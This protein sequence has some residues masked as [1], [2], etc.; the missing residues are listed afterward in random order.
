M[1]R[2]NRKY[3]PAPD[4]YEAFVIG[5]SKNVSWVRAPSGVATRWICAVFPKRVLMSSSRRVG[6]QSARLADRDSVYR[7]TSAAKPAGI[8]GIPS[9][10]RFSG[11]EMTGACVA[12][13]ACAA[14]AAGSN[15]ASETAR[16]SDRRMRRGPEEWIFRCSPYPRATPDAS[17]ATLSGSGH[18][19]AAEHREPLSHRSVHDSVADF[20]DHATEYRGIH[21]DVKHRLL[22]EHA[23]ELIGN[24]VA[25]A[26]TGLAGD[27][28][29]RVNATLRLIDEVVILRRDLRDQHL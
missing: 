2:V 28:D 26:L 18:D 17:A 12:C 1:S 20:H 4:S 27:S 3:R 10:T 6:C 29:I 23:R 24:R 15:C 9:A 11:G 25:L 14:R 5:S 7:R 8:G 19:P 21:V 16:M 13:A 22:A